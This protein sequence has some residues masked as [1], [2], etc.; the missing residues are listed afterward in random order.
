MPVEKKGGIPPM[1]VKFQR[2]LID[3]QLGLPSTKG[4]NRTMR[5]WILAP[6]VATAMLPLASAADDAA[7][8]KK[9]ADAN[10]AKMMSS[11]IKKDAKGVM[12]PY[13]DSFEGVGM[14]GQKVTK[15]QAETEMKQHMADTK[16]VN[17]AKF[18]ITGMK[19]NGDKATGAVGFHLD[20]VTVD[21]E[22]MMGPKGK[23]HKLVMDDQQNVTWSK[24]SGKWLI[25]KEAPTGKTKMMVDGK[26]FNPGAPPPAPKKK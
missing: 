16:K 5:K 2:T 10:Y 18:N 3:W 23:T 22:G 15:A 21:N 4:G 8:V 25:V 12:A 26:P 9:Q 19:V 13:A 1:R 20:C 11:F 6:I 14:M 17:V 24:T 7:A